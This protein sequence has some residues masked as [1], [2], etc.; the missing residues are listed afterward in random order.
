MAT[1]Y[2]GFGSLRH[3]ARTPL[4]PPR[5]HARVLMPWLIRLAAHQSAAVGLPDPANGDV[6]RDVVVG[7]Q[8][9]YGLTAAAF[10]GILI[11]TTFEYDYWEHTPNCWACWPVCMAAI[12]AQRRAPLCGA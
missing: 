10:L 8:S 3:D 5:A 1:E 11:A 7:A 4:A 6:G 2:N 9:V 12:G